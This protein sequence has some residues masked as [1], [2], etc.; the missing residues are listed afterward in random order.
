MRWDKMA[1]THIQWCRHLSGVDIKCAVVPTWSYMF[2]L[3]QE[4]QILI[5]NHIHITLHRVIVN[6][7]YENK[8]FIGKRKCYINKSMVDEIYYI[9]SLCLRDKYRFSKGRSWKLKTGIPTQ[10]PSS[11]K[12]KKKKNSICINY[13]DHWGKGILV[14]GYF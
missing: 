2:I 7:K 11:F 4:I 1:Q 13:I 3:Y 12:L 8:N 14:C 10:L 5:L 9:N 6:I